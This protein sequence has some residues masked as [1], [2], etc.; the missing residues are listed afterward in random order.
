MRSVSHIGAVTEIHAYG[1][2][3]TSRHV[4]P[5]VVMDTQNTLVVD[6]IERLGGPSK[7]AAA[8]N[9]KHPSV[10]LNWR[11]RKAVPAGYVLAIESLTGISRHDLR[12]DVF[13]KAGQ[14]A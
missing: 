7:A 10:I 5:R 11:R 13:G 2:A 14:A 6:V 9:L 12:P 4:I 8:L 1:L 3:L